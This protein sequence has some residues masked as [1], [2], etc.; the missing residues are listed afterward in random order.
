MSF[1]HR[2][3]FDCS[4]CEADFTRKGNLK[5]HMK[6]RCK[7]KHVVNKRQ[8]IATGSS[9]TAS[10]LLSLVGAPSL[11]AELNPGNGDTAAD[12]EQHGD[13]NGTKLFSA[14]QKVIVAPVNE[15]SSSVSKERHAELLQNE[16]ISL[17]QNAPE[18]SKQLMI[19]LHEMLSSDYISPNE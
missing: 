4:Q 17:Y 19:L 11:S 2:R 16:F 12:K 18:N 13:I 7:K 9:L 8:K 1:L 10:S 3:R 15:R 6:D 5:R 14:I